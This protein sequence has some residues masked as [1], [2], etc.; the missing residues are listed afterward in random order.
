MDADLFRELRSSDVPI[1]DPIALFV[2][3]G[4]AGDSISPREGIRRSW[5]GLTQGGG[6]EGKIVSVGTG[7]ETTV[8][9][10]QAAERLTSTISTQ[11]R[12]PW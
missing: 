4:H 2:V 6:G 7:G 8:F 1:L 11:G 9:E 3:Q 12:R 10:V 5:E